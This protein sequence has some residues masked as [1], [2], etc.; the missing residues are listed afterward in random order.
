M[1]VSAQDVHHYDRRLELGLRKLKQNRSL[2]EQN[3]EISSRLSH[4]KVP[5][6]LRG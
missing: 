1:P 2:S 3:W 5:V 6:T 4:K